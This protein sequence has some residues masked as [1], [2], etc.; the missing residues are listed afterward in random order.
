[1]PTEAFDDGDCRR[2]WL[3]PDEVD[4]VL[5][6]AG[7]APNGAVLEAMGEAPNGAERRLAAALGLRC[8]LRTVGDVRD[9][10]STAPVV[11]TSTRSLR[12]WCAAAGG[13]LR[14]ETGDDRWRY[15]SPHDW[16]RTWAGRL[17]AADVDQQTA[18]LW[19]G[20]DNLETFLDHY[21]GEATPEEQQRERE[22]VG[23]L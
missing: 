11:G 7:E 10:P 20:W 22:K 1:M 8:G 18:F 16:R 14:G 9:A 4:A 17:A 13:D 3:G 15:L 19:G 5:E 21:R 12:R 2:V 6:S 23:W